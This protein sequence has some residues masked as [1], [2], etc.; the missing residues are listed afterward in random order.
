MA[1]ANKIVTNYYESEKEFFEQIIII[2]YKL[3]SYS[4][5]SLD[6]SVEYI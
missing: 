4:K 3:S 1:T 5:S 6:R 2:V